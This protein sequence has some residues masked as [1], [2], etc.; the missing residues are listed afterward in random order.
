VVG[1]GGVEKSVCVGRGE[2]DGVQSVVGR[3]C[4]QRCTALLF[5]KAQSIS[6][7]N[8]RPHFTAPNTAI[9]VSQGT[10][11]RVEVKLRISPAEGAEDEEG[12][13]KGVEM[14]RK[15]KLGKGLVRVC[16]CVCVCACVCVCLC[17]YVRGRS[18]VCG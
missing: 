3:M 10:K 7:D 18:C 5:P 17:V 6:Q 13:V 16:V 11:G 9:D 2:G 1:S 15:W 12:D 14:W 8:T 4:T